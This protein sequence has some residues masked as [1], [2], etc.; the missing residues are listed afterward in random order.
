MPNVV[1]GSD[2]AGVVKAVGSSVHAFQVGDAIITHLAPG[3]VDSNGDDAPAV[4]ADISGGLGQTL[5]GTLRSEGVFSESALVHAPKT[6]GWLQASTLTCSG[7][8]AWNSL[9]GLKGR[10]P[11][12]GSWVLVQGTGGV[13]VAALQLASA[14]GATV[15]ATTSSEDKATRLRELGA[16]YTINYR[17]NPGGWGQEARTLTPGGRGFDMVVDIGGNATL[18]QSLS[19]VRTDGVV[20]AAG[21]VGGEAEPVPLL[22][23]LAHACIVRGVLLGSRNQLRDLVRFV[24]EKGVIPVIDDVVFELADAKEAYRFLSEQKHFSKVVIRIDHCSDKT[25]RQA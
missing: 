19:A 3:A 6:L 4:F 18:A 16:K 2:G 10:E 8:T 21:L 23:A 11:G 5:D 20:V 17:P 1:P 14:V 7:L 15:V 9:F 25:N 12:P 24:D 22:Y 13:S